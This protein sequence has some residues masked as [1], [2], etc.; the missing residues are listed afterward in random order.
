MGVE[1]YTESQTGAGVWGIA[2]AGSLTG[3]VLKPQAG[4][5]GD[6]QVYQGNAVLGTADDG[7]GVTAINNSP[8]G[9]AT[10]YAEGH[11]ATNAGGFLFDAISTGF[12]GYCD[13][14]NKGNL[15]CSGTSSAVIPVEGGSRHVAVSAIESPENWFEDFGSGQLSN[16][17]AVISLDST[18][19][20]TVNTG[21]NYH[22]FRTPNGDSRGLYVFAKSATSFEVREQGGGAS[23]IA[24][25]YRIVAKR[26]GFENVRLEDKTKMIRFQEAQQKQRSSDVG[27]TMPSAQELREKH[28]AA[29]R[30]V[31]PFTGAEVKKVN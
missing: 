17:S 21:V 26:K 1:G 10:I 9:F 5:W 19:V 29:A 25:D 16:G 12:G 8:T 7:L 18:F 22:V 11:D 30:R 13:I 14:D 28:R 2:Y 4:V 6:T 15:T 20:Q 23:S 27:H 3:T 31:T 24:F